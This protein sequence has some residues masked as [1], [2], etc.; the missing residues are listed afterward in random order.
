MKTDM[1]MPR[2]RQFVTGGHNSE[3]LTSSKKNNCLLV[4]SFPFTPRSR[5]FVTGGHNSE[6]LTSSPRSRQFVTGGHNSE[7]LTSSKN[8][9]CP[10]GNFF[11]HLLL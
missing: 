8:N 2:S 5:Q 7:P 6:P 1:P 3:P 11:F 4:I 10:T 9:N